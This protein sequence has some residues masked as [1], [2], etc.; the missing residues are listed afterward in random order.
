MNRRFFFLIVGLPMSSRRW[1]T[2]I[3]SF[4]PP[5]PYYILSGCVVCSYHHICRHR[6]E[7]LQAYLLPGQ[8]AAGFRQIRRGIS[9]VKTQKW[10]PAVPHL[11]G[12]PCTNHGDAVHGDP[13]LHRQRHSTSRVVHHIFCEPVVWLLFIPSGGT[14]L[15]HV[16][17]VLLH[18]QCH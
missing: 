10:E 15:L 12:Y 9:P 14:V 16:Y 7:D 6:A 8:C 3:F 11:T 17:L 4:I 13:Q 5:L 2:E 1:T 18:K